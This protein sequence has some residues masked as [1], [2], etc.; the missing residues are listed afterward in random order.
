M[1][2]GIMNYDSSSSNYINI[3]IRTTTSSSRAIR[4]TPSDVNDQVVIIIND[5]CCLAD[6]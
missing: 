4:R 6:Y 5:D 3:R 2:I 1:I